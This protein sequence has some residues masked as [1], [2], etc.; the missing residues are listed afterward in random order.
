MNWGTLTIAIIVIYVVYY[1]VNIGIDLLRSKKENLSGGYE[2]IEIDDDNDEEPE[3]ISTNYL[4]ENGIEEFEGV[5]GDPEESFKNQDSKTGS[6]T[7]S[8]GIVETQGLP[9]DEFLKKAKELS[10]GIEF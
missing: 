7:I 10:L 5:V 2:V 4:E 6:E 1:A 9:V 8:L 3:T